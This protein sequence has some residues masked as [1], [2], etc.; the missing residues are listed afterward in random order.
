MFANRY[1]ALFGSYGFHVYK[2]ITAGR[3]FSLL[4]LGCICATLVRLSLQ[5]DRLLALAS[6]Y[7]NRHDVV[8]IQ[9]AIDGPLLQRASSVRLVVPTHSVNLHVLLT[10]EVLRY[11]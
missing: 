1:P 7:R 3:H 8:G 5:L 11:F 6:T 10:P 2:A 9:V 4:A